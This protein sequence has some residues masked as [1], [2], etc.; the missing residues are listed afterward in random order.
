M[1]AVAGPAPHWLGWRCQGLVTPTLQALPRLG[2]RRGTKE[3]WSSN[4]L[5]SRN[6]A[7]SSGVLHQAVA[8]EVTTASAI[9]CRVATTP[10]SAATGVPG[11]THLLAQRARDRQTQPTSPR[12]QKHLV[13]REH[14]HHAT[15]TQ[16]PRPILC[17]TSAPSS[18]ARFGASL[19]AGS[20][21][22]GSISGTGSVSAYALAA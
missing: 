2:Q 5:V 8:G 7:R 9:G 21:G 14:N 13:P 15:P 4:R 19:Q 17:G 10:G 22:W 1:G 12:S 11:P 16:T 20:T 18:S 6:A 3:S